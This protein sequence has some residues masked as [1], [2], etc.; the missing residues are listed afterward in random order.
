[1]NGGNQSS[2][3]NRRG[4]LAVKCNGA[5]N[6]GD[7]HIINQFVRATYGGEQD[8]KDTGKEEKGPLF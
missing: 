5:S 8:K 2:L 4:C 3:K 7:F 6:E 1:M